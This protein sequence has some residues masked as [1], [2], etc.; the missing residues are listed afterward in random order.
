MQTSDGQPATGS[1]KSR[2]LAKMK[3]R[4]RNDDKQNK[5]S[6]QNSTASGEA[7]QREDGLLVG[8]LFFVVWPVSPQQAL[9]LAV[10]RHLVVL[11]LDRY[12][13]EVGHVGA[14]YLLPVLGELDGA[15]GD[16][17]Q[18]PVRKRVW[19]SHMWSG[20]SERPRLPFVFRS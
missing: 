4:N 9:Q 7:V 18:L 17:L 1:P 2:A 20:A 3:S 15:A 14:G 16:Q 8:G 11:V 13:R 5:I 6:H 19:H 10:L 12:R